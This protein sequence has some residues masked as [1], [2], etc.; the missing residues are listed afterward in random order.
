MNHQS[1]FNP[2]WFA[3]QEFLN[4]LNFDVGKKFVRVAKS[5]LNRKSAAN[6]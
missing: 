2:E 4:Y 5:I 1:F 6:R 3:F